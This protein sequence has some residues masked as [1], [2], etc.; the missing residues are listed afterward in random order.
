MTL[1]LGSP[2]GEQIAGSMD[3]D[4][5]QLSDRVRVIGPGEVPQDPIERRLVQGESV[6]GRDP[7]RVDPVAEPLAGVQDQ[8]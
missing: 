3:E 4:S 2:G 6:A 5:V 1:D 7:P 8:G